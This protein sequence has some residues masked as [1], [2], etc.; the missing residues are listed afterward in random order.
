MSTYAEH[1]IHDEVSL[2]LPWYVNGS[3]EESQK[4]V[5]EGHIHSCIACRRAL[6][7]E[8]RTLDMFRNES[9]LDQ[10]VQAGYARLH[11]R[12]AARAPAPVHAQS[13]RSVQNVWHRF[14]S[15]FGSFVD[16]GFSPDIGCCVAGSFGCW[17]HVDAVGGGSSNNRV[18]ELAVGDQPRLPRATIHLQV[19]LLRLPTWTM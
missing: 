2:L 15:A 7:T 5:I 9:P 19:Q 17:S 13:T 14:V 6:S 16:G 8:Y 12:I 3:M 1:S 11:N 4:A 18:A 10:S